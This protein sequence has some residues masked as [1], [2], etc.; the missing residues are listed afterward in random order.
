MGVGVGRSRRFQVWVAAVVGRC[1][2][3][4]LGVRWAL[5]G[6]RGFDRL[7]VQPVAAVARWHR[8]LFFLVVS[9]V[10]GR[11]LLGRSMPIR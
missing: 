6:L 7:G 10:V 11:L 3:W 8:G 2:V 1:R 5:L 4:V 9:L